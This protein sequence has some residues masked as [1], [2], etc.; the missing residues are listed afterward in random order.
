MAWANTFKVCAILDSNGYKDQYQQYDLLIAAGVNRELEQSVGT[1]FKALKDFYDENP[2]WMFGLLSYDLKNEVENLQSANADPLGFPD[3]YFFVPQYLL[4]VKDDSVYIII[5]DK[6][7][8]LEIENTTYL[9]PPFQPVAIQRSMT[10]AEYLKKVEILQAHILKGDCYEATFCQNFFAENAEIDPLFVFNQLNT[11]S[12]SPFAGYFKIRDQYILS[13][14]PERFLC[15]RGNQ[16]SSQPIKGTA[17]RSDN[18]SKD[19]ELQQALKHNQKEQA[20]N[21]MIVDLVRNDLTKSAVPGTVKVSELFGI[22]TFPQVHQMISTIT[23]KL[24]PDIHFID[25]IKNTF[26]MGSMTGAPKIKAMEFIE[27]LENEKRGAFSGAMGYLTPQGDFDFNVIIRS[28]LYQSSKKY[29][30]FNVGSAIT[31][32]ANAACEYEECLL[33]AEAM[34]S[35]L[36]GLN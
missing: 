30:S 22:Y 31:F 32:E 7:V 5:G 35:T 3:L 33:K 9:S 17:K 1:A 8:L 6:E 28:L 15:K 26:P 4:A 19:H 11:I 23:C 24:K 29:L 25:A 12:P 36:K 34:L 2:S 21:V 14:S 18:P 16:L 13:A 27:E 10:K 20:E